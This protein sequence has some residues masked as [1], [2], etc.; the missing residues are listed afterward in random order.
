MR[1][2]H[3]VVIGILL[4]DI[5]IFLSILGL[6]KLAPPPISLIVALFYVSIGL[7]GV[8]VAVA[9]Y[10]LIELFITLW[11]EKRK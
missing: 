9:V 4:V 2:L 6:F 8:M 11:Q 5:L 7:A 3:S 10:L 1:R